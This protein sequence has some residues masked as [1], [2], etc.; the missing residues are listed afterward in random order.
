L[1]NV[2]ERKPSRLGLPFENLPSEQVIEKLQQIKPKI[3]KTKVN[4]LLYHGEL[5]DSFSPEETL[6]KKESAGICP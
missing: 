1:T 6:A 5:V 2:C 4:V 3:D